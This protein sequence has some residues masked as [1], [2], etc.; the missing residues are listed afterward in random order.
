MGHLDC[1]VQHRSTFL[2]SL[3]SVFFRICAYNYHTKCVSAS[4][5]MLVKLEC[6]WAMPAGNSIVS[7][8]ASSLM[9]KCH[10]TKLLEEVTIPSTPS[11]LRLAL[12]NMFPG[13]SSS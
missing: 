6:R 8:M 11:S 7:S 2:P 9:V 13:Q 12:E 5:F 10:Q 1:R 3:L 4:L